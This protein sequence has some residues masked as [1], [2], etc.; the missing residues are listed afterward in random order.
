MSSE[1]VVII[2]Y[3][4]FFLNSKTIANRCQV[5]Y[6]IRDGQSYTL[7]QLHTMI[8]QIFKKKKN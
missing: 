2:I 4:I 7:L 5:I 3:N 1:L 8:K 6:A